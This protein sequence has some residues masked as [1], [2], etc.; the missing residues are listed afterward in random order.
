M[1]DA[2]GCSQ[3]YIKEGDGG[4]LVTLD[5]EEGAVIGE[6]QAGQV[7]AQLVEAGEPAPGGEW[8]FLT[9]K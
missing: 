6:D 5:G 7:V 9:Y 1:A 2:G 8:C 3:F 4:E